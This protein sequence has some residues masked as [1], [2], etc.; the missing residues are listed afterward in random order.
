MEFTAPISPSFLLALPAAVVTPLEKLLHGR[1]TVRV[2]ATVRPI[3]Y[4][5]PFLRVDFFIVLQD[6]RHLAGLENTLRRNV[7]SLAVLVTYDPLLLCRAL[8][9]CHS[10]CF[11]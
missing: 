9:M 2:F 3:W 5:D 11:I 7:S 1:D 6:L 4:S 8:Y 10:S